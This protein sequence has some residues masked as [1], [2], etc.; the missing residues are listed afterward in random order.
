RRTKNNYGLAPQQIRSKF[1]HRSLLNQTPASI[2]DRRAVGFQ[3][4]KYF[5]ACFLIELTNKNSSIDSTCGRS[6]FDESIEIGPYLGSGGKRL[7]KCLECIAALGGIT[8]C[9]VVQMFGF[10]QF[11]E[12]F[13]PS[14][15]AVFLN[16]FEFCRRRSGALREAA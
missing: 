3:S 15:N 7:L 9:R 12:K 8:D 14:H 5:V 16:F 10:G 1:P 4:L 11:F 6:L 13:G 2:V